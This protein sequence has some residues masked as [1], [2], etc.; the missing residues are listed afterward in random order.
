MN[1][2]T[3]IT[4]H[5]INRRGISGTSEE[6]DSKRLRERLHRGRF[7]A[8]QRGGIDRFAFWRKRN[9]RCLAWK[10]KG[11]AWRRLL[12]V[13]EILLEGQRGK[14]KAK[15]SAVLV[16]QPPSILTKSVKVKKS[17]KTS[18]RKRGGRCRKRG[19]TGNGRA[20]SVDGTCR[21]QDIAI[22]P[23]CVAG[24]KAQE[25]HFEVLLASPP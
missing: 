17:A 11:R 9:G 22:A 12:R 2:K 1:L 18:W 25:Q 16:V 3:V 4:T 21:S 15:A 23:V 13:L 7:C 24:T 5:K 14:V 10:E 19:T 8:Q 6:C 20:H